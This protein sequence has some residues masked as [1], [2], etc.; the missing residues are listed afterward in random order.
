ML[1]NGVAIVVFAAGPAN[2]LQPPQTEFVVV[3]HHA[4]RT[5]TSRALGITSKWIR[6]WGSRSLQ[7]RAQCV[8]RMATAF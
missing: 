3:L 6:M 1:R 7:W 4:V 8:G 5:C 2:T